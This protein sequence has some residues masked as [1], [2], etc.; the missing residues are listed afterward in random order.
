LAIRPATRVDAALVDEGFAMVPRMYFRC[1]ASLLFILSCALAGNR[2]DQHDRP[3]FVLT[4]AMG[5]QRE[6]TVSEIGAGWAVRLDGRSSTPVAG[7]DLVALRQARV[8]LPA[9]PAGEHVRLVNGDCLAARVLQLKGERLQVRTGSGAETELLVP[10]ASLSVI[11]LT[12]PESALDPEVLLRRL[13]AEKRTRD[14]VLLRNGEI[15]HGILISLDR[16][17]DL[18]LEVDKKEVAVEFKK[19]AAVALNTELARWRRPPAPYAHLVLLDGSRL[20]LATGK[21]EASTLHGRTLFGADVAVPLHEIVALDMRQGRA[22]YLSDLKPRRYEFNSYLGGPDWPFTS[23]ASVAGGDLKLGGS[24]YDKGLGMHSASR[25]TF[26]LAGG[27]RRFEA[28]V[29]LDDQTGAAG[30]VR[31]RVLVDGKVHDF[32][33]DK[34]LTSK[35]GPHVVQLDVQGARELTLVVDFGR[36]ADVQDHVDWADARLIK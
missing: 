12:T 29:G 16:R 36:H 14:S 2:A 1:C 32:L 8:P 3:I 27:Y 34:D 28:M 26:D 4:Q 18:R 5:P 21:L 30:S 23:D 15:L 17:T 35:T 25:L 20:A 33:G 31:V 24:V 19:V 7:A 22:V 9:R 13:A 10:L 11:W 6:G